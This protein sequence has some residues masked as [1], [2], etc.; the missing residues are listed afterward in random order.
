VFKG[1]YDPDGSQKWLEGV[2]RIFR[3][4]RCTEEQKVTLGT[5][6]L[7]EEVEYWWRSTSQRLGVGNVVMTWENFKGEFLVKYFPADV[8]NKKVIEFLEPKQG[9]MY[10]ARDA[11]K[12]EDLCRFSPHYKMVEAEVDKCVNFESGLCPNIKQLIGF[13]EIRNFSTLV[14]M[15]RICDEDGKAKYTYYKIMNDNRG[16]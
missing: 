13:S 11:A 3:D 9:N 2:E 10:V 4:M 16:E 1:G 14:N 12:F 6:V 15:C 5:F 7:H 8:R